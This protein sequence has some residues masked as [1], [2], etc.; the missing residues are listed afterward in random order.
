MQFHNIFITTI[1]FPIKKE[2]NFKHF[3]KFSNLSAPR[4][5]KLE[6]SDCYSNQLYKR[7]YQHFEFRLSCFVMIENYIFIFFCKI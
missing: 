4:V 3:R 6:S 1:F 5:L 2:R 7:Q